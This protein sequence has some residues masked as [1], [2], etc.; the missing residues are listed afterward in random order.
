MPDQI[1][2]NCRA[3]QIKGNPV[4]SDCLTEKQLRLLQGVYLQKEEHRPHATTH[5]LRHDGWIM[6]GLNTVA[7]GK[8]QQQG[9][10][11]LRWLRLM[12]LHLHCF[13][14]PKEGTLKSMQEGLYSHLLNIVVNLSVYTYIYIYMHMH[15]SFS[16]KRV[17]YTFYSS[18]GHTLLPLTVGIQSSK[19]N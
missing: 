13:T 18:Y 12:S 17:A 9:Q 15:C 11:Q 5:C 4:S 8:A 3:S 2:L 1:F 7:S 6:L 10:I 19:T 14:F 16:I